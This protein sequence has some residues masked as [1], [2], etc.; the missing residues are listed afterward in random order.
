[1]NLNEAKIILNKNGYQLIK[2]ARGL[3]YTAKDIFEELWDR[4][5]KY[6]DDSNFNDFRLLF[7]NG[8]NNLKLPEDLAAKYN[9]SIKTANI[10]Y[11]DGIEFAKCK[12]DDCI[13]DKL[14]DKTVDEFY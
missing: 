11:E 9:A 2:E 6:W 8:Y 3:T 13:Q 5:Y 14:A 4:S 10:V 1:M 12:T 7:M